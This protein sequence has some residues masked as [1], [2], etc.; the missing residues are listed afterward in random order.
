M[1]L[2]TAGVYKKGNDH[3]KV[4]FIYWDLVF[5]DVMYLALVDHMQ[6]TKLIRSRGLPRFTKLALSVPAHC[7]QPTNSSLQHHHV[8][9]CTLFQADSMQG[10][11]GAPTKH[12][13]VTHARS[14]ANTH[15]RE[16]IV[17]QFYG[18]DTV[19]CRLLVTAIQDIQLW[20]WTCLKDERK[21]FP[22]VFQVIISGH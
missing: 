3:L 17:A 10:M 7:V 19:T 8:C 4:W 11:L 18:N 22:T 20:I 14:D 1:Y 6:N 9:A 16:L 13:C 5:G 12:T 15:R 2:S 21:T